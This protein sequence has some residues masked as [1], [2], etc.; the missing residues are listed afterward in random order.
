ME[1]TFYQGVKVIPGVGVINKVGE[2]LR[3]VGYQKAFLV[4][5]EGIRK[6]GVV[7]KIEKSLEQSHISFV[8][9]SKVLPD[10]PA[11]IINEGAALCKENE[12][13]CVIGIGGGSAI[14][15]A[16]GI[17]ILRFN[18]GNI[19]EYATK[20]IKHCTGLI[21]I[22]TTSGTGSELS[23]GA[24]ISD[25]EHDAKIPVLCANCMSEY[26]ILDPELTVGMPSGLTMMT[27]LDVFS[28]AAEAYTAITSNMM[29][30]L[31][32]EKVLET[33]AQNL[34]IAVKDGTN[35]DARTKMQAAAS[36]GGW[37]LYNCCAHVGHSFAHVIGGNFHVIHGA[38]CAYGLPYVLKEIVVAVPQKVKKI[39]EIL[40]A[41]F[42]GDEKPDE[43]AK[44]SAEAYI[45]FTKRLGLKDISEWNIEVKDFN[46]LVQEVINEP[47]AG[48]T[49]IKVDEAVASR[50]IKGALNL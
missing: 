44:K 18:D 50:I 23:N 34:E 10:P 14:D 26:T 42:N 9:F 1:F 39:G 30:D 16:K 45:A 47:F 40:G 13:D 38:A 48:L 43:I 36:I 6:V 20:E 21:T 17:N 46:K 24:I 2:L 3:D 35:I 11:H 31:V 27:G 15:S 25:V 41:Q 12:C 49:P 7:D 5:D 4:F 29:T 22:P 28:H 37:M 33:V 19:L 8:E 32:C